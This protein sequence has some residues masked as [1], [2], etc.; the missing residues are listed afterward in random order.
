VRLNNIDAFEN[1]NASKPSISIFKIARLKKIGYIET[2]SSSVIVSIS[3]STRGGI[4]CSTRFSIFF[5]W[6]C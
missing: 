2:K 6:W 1:A 4:P 5:L 3:A